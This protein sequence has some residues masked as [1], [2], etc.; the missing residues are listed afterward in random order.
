MS[1][2]FILLQL[3]T[4]QH[5]RTSDHGGSISFTQRFFLFAGVFL[6]PLHFFQ[7]GGVFLLVQCHAWEKASEMEEKVWFNY[8]QDGRIAKC[9]MSSRWF[10]ECYLFFLLINA[11]LEENIQSKFD[12]LFQVS[13]LLHSSRQHE[14]LITLKEAFSII[15]R[16]IFQVILSNSL[17]YI[18]PSL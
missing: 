7:L 11:K 13:T 1:Y 2:P 16:Q 18:F 9:G 14:F 6:I 4:L 3:S 8:G 5:Q 12:L 15:P 10:N 17:E